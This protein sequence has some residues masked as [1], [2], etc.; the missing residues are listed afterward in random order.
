[1]KTLLQILGPTGVGKSRVA[2]TLAK[3]F[4]GEIISADSM[5]VYRGFDIGTAKPT[6]AE[7]REVPHHLIDTVSDCSQFNAFRFLNESFA[8]AEA[9]LERGRLPIVCGGTALYLSV[10]KAGIFSEPA[11]DRDVRRDLHARI[12]AEGLPA[13]WEELRRVDEPY[14]LK[15]GTNDRR[16]VLRALEIFASTGVAPSAMFQKN[17]TPFRAYRIIRIGLNRER[18]A[19]YRL[20]EQRVD[21]M[22]ASGLVAEVRRLRDTRPPH[23]PPFQAVGYKE[24]VLALEGHVT[25]AEAVDLI[26]RHSRNLCKRQLT[27]FR[28]EKDIVWFAPDDLGPLERYLENELWNGR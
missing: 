24:T 16:R 19:L 9:I 11:S 26:K 1:M 5:Q 10:M 28:R 27:W 12:E 3:K 20:I 7:R 18:A 6:S 17:E 25:L 14:A 4:S 8:C 15:I 21:A 23:C 2:L 22:I 13:L